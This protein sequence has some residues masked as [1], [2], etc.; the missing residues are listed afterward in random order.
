MNDVVQL[1]PRPH[2]II[3]WDVVG[4]TNRTDSAKAYLRS[5]MYRLIHAALLK[6][7]ITEGLRKNLDRGDGAI[8]LVKQTDDVPKTALLHIFVPTLYDLLVKHANKHPERALQM[9]VAIHSGEVHFD[10]QGPFGEGAFGEA[11]DVTCRLVEA[12]VLKDRLQQSEAPLV[13]AVSDHIYRTIV[14]HGY[15]GI[16]RRSFESII[17]FEV[18][19]Q[20]HVGWVQTPAGLNGVDGALSG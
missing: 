18:S 14:W 4:S 9:R 16:D 19:G 7:R 1:Q 11:I 2:I 17:A 6:S 5:D 20:P 3:A 13:L 10:E 12:Q 15:R 8:T